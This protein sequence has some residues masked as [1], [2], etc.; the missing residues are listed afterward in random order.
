M[1]TFYSF[2]TVNSPLL[3]R[4]EKEAVITFAKT[5]TTVVRDREKIGQ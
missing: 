3:K 4:K 1:I 2:S 5:Y